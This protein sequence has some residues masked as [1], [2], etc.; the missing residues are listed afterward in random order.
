MFND[1]LDIYQI[2]LIYLFFRVKDSYRLQFVYV[3]LVLLLDRLSIYDNY[4]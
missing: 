1:V 2:Y 3:L 4:P